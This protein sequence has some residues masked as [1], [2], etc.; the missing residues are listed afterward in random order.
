MQHVSDQIVV[1]TGQVTPTFPAIY[2]SF[3]SFQLDNPASWTR[4]QPF[5]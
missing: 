4:G 1:D 2:P 3:D 5:D